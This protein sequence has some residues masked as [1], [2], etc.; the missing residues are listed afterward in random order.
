MVRLLPPRESWRMRVSLELRYGMNYLPEAAF[1]SSVRAA[2]T[3]PRASSPWLIWIPSCRVFPVAPVFLILS[4]PARSTKWNF[5]E[6]FSSEVTGS[7]SG[8]VASAPSVG[9]VTLTIFCSIVTVKIACER[10]E[11]SFIFVALVIRCVMPL[12]RS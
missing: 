4:E 9:Y 6:I 3:F 1:F 10:D 5:A 7:A 8:P 12:L 2:M 11:A